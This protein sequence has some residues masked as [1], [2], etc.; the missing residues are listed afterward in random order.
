[1]LLLA[2]TSCSPSLTPFSQ[3]LYDR[4]RWSDDELKHIQFYLSD[5]IVLHK[6]GD[7]SE[8]QIVEGKIR[9]N[10][11]NTGERITIKKGT[12][13]VLLFSPKSN[14]FAISFHEN[15][16]SKYLMFGPNEAINGKYALLAK[17]WEKYRGTVTYQDQPYTVNSDDAMSV[18]LVDLKKATRNKIEVREEK[19]RKVE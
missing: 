14:R 11:E 5:D 3:Q 10:K 1:M 8:A 16:D 7:A 18:L 19:G 2:F 13:G 4:Y 15:D 17:D 6:K 9:I 12:P